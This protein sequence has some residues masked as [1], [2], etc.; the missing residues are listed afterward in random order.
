MINKIKTVI[1]LLCMMAIMIII[2]GCTNSKDNT[3]HM[4]NFLDE[5]VENN[6]FSSEYY[7]EMSKGFHDLYAEEGI[8]ELTVTDIKKIETGTA[9]LNYSINLYRVKYNLTNSENDNRENEI[10]MLFLFKDSENVDSD[11]EV[12]LL[13]YQDEKFILENFKGEEYKD[14]PDEYTAYAMTKY[15]ETK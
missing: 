7:E 12:S 3:L 11:Y 5:V 14:F 8:D 10:M 1:E 13:D 9:A 4:V 15:N 6:F 2:A